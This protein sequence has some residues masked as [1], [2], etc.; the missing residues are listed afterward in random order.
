MLVHDMEL[1]RASLLEIGRQ[2]RS[3]VVIIT[4]QVYDLSREST[5]TLRFACGVRHP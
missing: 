2:C 4:A 3:E 5:R 1:N